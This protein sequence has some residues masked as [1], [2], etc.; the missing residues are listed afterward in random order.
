MTE[1]SAVRGERDGAMA[2]RR[3]V[4]RMH[5]AIRLALNSPAKA[6]MVA[7]KFTPEW[8]TRWG[9][10]ARNND[11]ATS[12]HVATR[13]HS[14]A[15]QFGFVQ[16]GSR[17]ERWHRLALSTAAQRLPRDMPGLDDARGCA[18]VA[19]LTQQIC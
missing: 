9:W 3:R 14:D 6:A 11:A 15:A 12:S 8:L 10:D 2:R 13:V 4:Q 5:D 16:S 19:R 17:V 1:R 18:P 7:W